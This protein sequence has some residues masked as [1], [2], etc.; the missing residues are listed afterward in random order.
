TAIPFDD[1]DEEYLQKPRKWQVDDI[2][3]FM[4]FIGPVSSVFD[5]TPFSLLWV[6]FGADT[7]GKQAVFPSGWVVVGPVSQTLIIH[8]IRT[9]KVPF[10]QSWASPPLILL[11]LLIMA[12]GVAIPFTPLGAA[13]GLVPL[14]WAYFPWLAATLLSYCALTQLIKVWYIR[15]F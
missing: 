3:R 13:V 9:A 4:V 10:F 7:V 11:T 1:V 8:M 12:V 2:G 6:V 5:L 15:R 14:P